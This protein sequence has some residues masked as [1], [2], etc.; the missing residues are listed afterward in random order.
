MIE[1]EACLR[2]RGLEGGMFCLNF[3]P[4]RVPAVR[5]V[6]CRSLLDRSPT[7]FWPLCCFMLLRVL[8]LVC[9]PTARQRQS[10]QGRR[11]QVDRDG[12]GD[13]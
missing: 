13:D 4:Q 10:R 1:E 2:A 8:F 6:P 5:R 9:R 12:D 11:Q 3:L 7:P